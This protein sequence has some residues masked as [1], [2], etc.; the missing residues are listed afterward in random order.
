MDSDSD[1]DLKKAIALSLAA[2]DSS[3]RA[4]PSEVQSDEPVPLSSG[5]DELDDDDYDLKAAIALSLMEEPKQNVSESKPSPIIVDNTSDEEDD[6]DD[7][8]C[9]W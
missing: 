1:E 9:N 2:S 4:P 3:N 8:V 7:L 5:P 6:D